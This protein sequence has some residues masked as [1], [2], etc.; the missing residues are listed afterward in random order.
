MAK[1][2]LPS[3]S[4]QVLVARGEISTPSTSL[5]RRTRPRRC[6]EY[7]RARRG[8]LITMT[9]GDHCTPSTRRLVSTTVAG[10]PSWEARRGAKCYLPT[11]GDC[12]QIGFSHSSASPH[13]R[14]LF[15][16]IYAAVKLR[17]NES[18]NKL[19]SSSTSTE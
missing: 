10:R 3:V 14:R 13:V 1:S 12:A 18:R 19:T 6:L 7:A 16:D 17:R 8:T 15:L 11:C 5:R 4:C 9:A 2:K